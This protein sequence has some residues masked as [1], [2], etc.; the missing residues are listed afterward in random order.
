MSSETKPRIWAQYGGKEESAIAAYSAATTPLGVAPLPP[1][2]MEPWQFHTHGPHGGAPI[3]C[4]AGWVVDIWKRLPAGTPKGAMMFHDATTFLWPQEMG[5]GW[6]LDR[7]TWIDQHI[8]GKYRN[9]Q[10]A[11]AVHWLAWHCQQAGILPDLLHSQHE[12]NQVYVADWQ[13]VNCP[14]WP[15]IEALCMVGDKI[16]GFPKV[17][18]GKAGIKVLTA[19]VQDAWDPACI[20]FN[21]YMRNWEARGLRSVLDY[22]GWRGKVAYSMEHQLRVRA[23]IVPHPWR[24]GYVNGQVT[25]DTQTSHVYMYELDDAWHVSYDRALTQAYGPVAVHLDATMHADNTPRMTDVEWKGAL[26]RKHAR[27]I[28]DVM[29]FN[30]P[31]DDS[32]GRWSKHYSSIVGAARGAN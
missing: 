11:Q 15:I 6:G 28:G 8:T 13:G 5:Y 2:K 27:K 14:Q 21:R 1:I 3:P 17:C 32:N 7:A 9:A 30:A 20:A 12:G 23:P 18:V 31:P 19:A 24:P 16:A 4:T 25:P 10:P 22:A 29:I 26:V